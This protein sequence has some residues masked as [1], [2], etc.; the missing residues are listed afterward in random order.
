MFRLV[1]L[2]ISRKYTTTLFLIGQTPVGILCTAK[3]TQYFANR[4]SLV[5]TLFIDE[6][7]AYTRPIVYTTLEEDP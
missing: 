1:V 6:P 4:K 5:C 3:Q 2:H 7:I